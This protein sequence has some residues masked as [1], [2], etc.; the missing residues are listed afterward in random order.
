MELEIKVNTG[1][2]SANEQK[3]LV[4]RS[5]FRKSGVFAINIMGSPGSG[6]TTVLE[7]TIDILAGKVRLAV[8]EGDIYTSKDAKRIEKHGVPVEQINTGGACHLDAK[9]VS[10]ALNKFDLPGLDLMIVEN[11]GNLVCPVEFD[12]G[13]DLK[14]AVLSITEGD[15]KPMKYPL[16]FRESAAVILNKMDILEFT[17]VDLQA[18]RQDI[19]IINPGIKIFE[20]SARTGQGMDQWTEWLTEW[21]NNNLKEKTVK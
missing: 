3:A 20:V 6:K 15:D 16:L 19:Q 12:L 4:N 5:L 21:V 1:I 17:D 11:V 10:G 14:I 2:L 7:K 9:M 18:L 13:E 8:I